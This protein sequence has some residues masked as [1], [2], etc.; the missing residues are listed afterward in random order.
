MIMNGMNLA[1]LNFSHGTHEYH[2]GTIKN[3]REACQQLK[4]TPFDRPVAIA[5]DTKGPEIR[6]GLIKGVSLI[7]LFQVFLS[8]F[9][10]TFKK[11]TFLKLE[12]KL[13]EPIQNVLLDCLK[14]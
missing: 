4:G 3:V 9:F 2:E 6:T 8:I 10:E 5:L 11:I 13:Y 1:R 7:S 12:I 14:E